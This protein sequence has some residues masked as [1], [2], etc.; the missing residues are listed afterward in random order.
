M[1]PAVLM[2]RGRL[3]TSVRSVHSNAEL[4]TTLDDNYTA[5]TKVQGRP[6]GFGGRAPVS[7]VARIMLMVGHAR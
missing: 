6:S 7:G 2:D 5:K 4:H 1:S 3:V